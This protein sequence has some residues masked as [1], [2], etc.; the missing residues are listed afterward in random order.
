MT[1]KAYPAALRRTTALGATAALCAWLASVPPSLAQGEDEDA[2]ARPPSPAAEG[3]P[4]TPE[5]ATLPYT[6]EVTAGDDSDLA[7]LGRAVA[8]TVTLRERAPTDALGLLGRVRS[9]LPRLQEALRAEGYWGGQVTA[10]IDGLPVDDP[11]LPARLAAATGPV[12]VV[13]TLTPRD[14]YHIDHV[15]VIAEPSD[16]AAEVRQAALTADLPEGQPAR[17][18]AVLAAE[19]AMLD[20]LRA[21][22]HPLAT[23]AG[24]DITDLRYVRTRA[25][26]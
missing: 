22:G 26:P 1:F 16:A 11:A 8:Q 4:A 3:G 14:R 5:P 9:D 20:A 7:N 25:A 24:R 6:V 18:E 15:T 13:I 2:P 23:A 19:S 17:A 10:T 12:P 21:G